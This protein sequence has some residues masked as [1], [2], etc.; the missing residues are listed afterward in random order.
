MSYRKIE[1]NGKIYEYVI[2]QINIKIKGVGVFST[3]EVGSAATREEPEF[4]K[5]KPVTPANIRDLILKHA[6]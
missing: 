1:V 2:G 5:V 4:E 6:S 3:V